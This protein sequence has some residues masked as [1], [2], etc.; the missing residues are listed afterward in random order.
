M[1]LKSVDLQTVYT[2]SLK[3]SITLQALER[4]PVMALKATVMLF[5]FVDYHGHRIATFEMYIL[6]WCCN[7][8]NF[9]VS[10]LNVEIFVG[11]LLC[12]HNDCEHSDAN[13]K[14]DRIMSEAGCYELSM[15]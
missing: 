8:V 9:V 7:A 2:G 3:V 15:S 1:P 6:V 14:H 12:A 5:Y 10:V 4:A 11:Y 13:L